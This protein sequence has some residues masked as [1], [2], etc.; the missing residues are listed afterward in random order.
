MEETVKRSSD[1]RDRQGLQMVMETPGKEG[2]P[3][4]DGE[5][6]QAASKAGM[7]RGTKVA[8]KLSKLGQALGKALTQEL[9]SGQDTHKKDLDK[10]QR[11]YQ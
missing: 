7:A 10:L 5:G 9:M 4:A 2:E 3:V 1:L 6:G 8:C 11:S